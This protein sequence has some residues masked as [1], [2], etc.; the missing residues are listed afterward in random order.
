[1]NMP[2]AVNIYADIQRAYLILHSLDN[3]CQL[4]PPL[5]LEGSKSSSLFLLF[6]LLGRCGKVID[7]VGTA[8]K[9]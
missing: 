8:R 6:Q 4:M 5:P 9:K 1:M 2:V 7:L 3:R